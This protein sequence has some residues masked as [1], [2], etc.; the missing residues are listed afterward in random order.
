[1]YDMIY[2]YGMIYLYD[3]I[4][5][6]IDVWYI[7]IYLNKIY[8]SVL[9]INVKL[10]I[11]ITV[12]NIKFMITICLNKIYFSILSINVKLKHLKLSKRSYVR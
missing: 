4:Y 11:T 2:L 10:M 3:M 1:M 6:Y 7:T 12:S 8:F 5:F 9:S